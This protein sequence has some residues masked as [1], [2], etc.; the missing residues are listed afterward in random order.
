MVAF[1]SW[2]VDPVRANFL[3]SRNWHMDQRRQRAWA[4][5]FKSC[6]LADDNKLAKHVES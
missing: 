5:H 2:S 6:G 1:N 4:D 3:R